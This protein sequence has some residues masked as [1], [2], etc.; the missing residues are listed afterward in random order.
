MPTVRLAGYVSPDNF[1]WDLSAPDKAALLRT[2]AARITVRQ[3]GVDAE[4][5]VDLLEQRESIQSAGIGDGLALPHAMVPGTESTAL[6]V[7]RVTPPVSYA[8]LDDAPVDLVFLLLSPSDGLKQHIRL[9][10]RVARIVGRTDLLDRL[11]GAAGAEDAC[12]ILLDQDS[13]HIY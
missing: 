7:G 12:R 3:P 10:A 8:A 11:R 4:I 6:F 13:R 2:M 5:L 9:L 1:F